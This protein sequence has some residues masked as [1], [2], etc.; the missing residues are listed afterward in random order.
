MKRLQ[1]AIAFLREVKEENP[2]AG[3][4]ALQAAYAK[5][6]V[7]TKVGRSVYVG[8]GYALRFSEAK[9]ASFSNTVLALSELWKHDHQP[10]VVV[11]ARPQRVDFLL[12]NTTFLKKI[13]HSSHKLR[14]DNVRGSF[15]GT[16]ILTDYEGT[17]N[18]PENFEQLFALHEAFTWEENLA[19]LVEATNDIIVRS[20]RFKPTVAQREVLSSAPERASAALSS[21]AFFAVAAEL[22]A[23]VAAKRDAIVAASRLDN[24]NTRGNAIEQILSGGV[25]AHEIGDLT[26]ELEAGGRLVTDI[27][28]K[29]LGRTSAP[30][31]YNVDKMLALLAE[32]GTVFAFLFVGVN[33][34]ARTVTARL[35]P[36]FD[37]TLLRATA[38]QHH[39]AGRGSRGVAQ[40][41]GGFERVLAPTYR[42]RVDV[43]SARAFLEALL[44][45]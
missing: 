12:A 35:V 41:T 27:K 24:V 15:N 40:F 4:A 42:S 25:N 2:S 8:E 17:K 39:W 16:D 32:P 5:R 38:V 29:L 3:K 23:L 28:S 1:A 45:L 20:Q 37:E 6:F 30:K 33:T 43:A 7:P 36:V 18:C 21:R 10:F 14:L 9:K 13:S 31:A 44:A 34:A 11:I 19:R 22:Q 26:H